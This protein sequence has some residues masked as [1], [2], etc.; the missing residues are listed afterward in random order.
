L[1]DCQMSETVI[2]PN[3]PITEAIIDI[4]V[5]PRSEAAITALAAFRDIVRDRFPNGQAI[6]EWEADFQVDP[7]REP[8]LTQASARPTGFLFR[9]EDQTKIV[10]TTLTGF[11]FN[12]LR[13]YEHWTPFRDEAKQLWKQYVELI[14]PLRVI[15]V[16]LRY[17]NRIEIPMPFASFS[18]YIRTTPEIAPNLPQELVHFFLRLEIPWPDE[19]TIAVITETIDQSTLTPQR[20]PLIFDIDVFRAHPFDPTS[21]EVWDNLESLRNIKNEIFLSSLTDKAKEMFR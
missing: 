15:R 21:E 19:M 10:Q 8:T 4:R 16:A 11:T 9:S 5:E 1:R 6:A 20:V 12:K 2:F 7:P 17:I 3:A 18:E 14:E 13:P